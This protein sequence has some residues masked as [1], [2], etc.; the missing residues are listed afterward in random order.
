[1]AEEWSLKMYRLLS[2]F[3]TG[4]ALNKTIKSGKISY[5]VKRVLNIVIGRYIVSKLWFK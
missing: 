2:L 5:I 4:K 1:M 3:N